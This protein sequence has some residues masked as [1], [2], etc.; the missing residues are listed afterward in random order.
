MNEC[1]DRKVTLTKQLD[2]SATNAAHASGGAC[3]E[4]RVT[5]FRI[6]FQNP[7]T[8]TIAPCLLFAAPSYEA[9]RG[10]YKPRA[11]A[12]TN[13]PRP[14]SCKNVVRRRADIRSFRRNFARFVYPQIGRFFHCERLLE[15]RT[16]TSVHYDWRPD[17]EERSDPAPREPRAR[18]R[19]Q[20]EPLRQKSADR[21]SGSQRTSSRLSNNAY[22]QFLEPSTK[23]PSARAA[24]RPDSCCVN[25][26]RAF[27][28][29]CY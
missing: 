28:F 2:N 29:V 20:A 27:N 19:A 17:D 1:A 22:Q 4:D 8:R 16:R 7:S 15:L 23:P 11:I 9:C 18:N 3:N 13:I 14:P 21:I 25:A 12:L 5:S 6:Q 10:L 26:L 24:F